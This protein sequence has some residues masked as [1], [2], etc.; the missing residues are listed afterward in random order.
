MVVCWQSSAL[1]DFEMLHTHLC[2]QVHMAFSCVF[3]CVQ[4]SSFKRTQ[5][6]WIR[7][8]LND[9]AEF[10]RLQRSYFQIRAHSQMLL[11]RTS[12]DLENVIQLVTVDVSKVLITFLVK[13][14]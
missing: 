9:F 8:L 3:V 13:M 1:T 14:L 5:S 4:I 11:A 7:A 6:C 12:T 2:F 10:D